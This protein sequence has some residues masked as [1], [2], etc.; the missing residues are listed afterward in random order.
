V[1]NST[2]PIQSLD[3]SFSCAQTQA[4]AACMGARNTFISTSSVNRW[5]QGLINI[6]K[7]SQITL[8]PHFSSCRKPQEELLTR[9]STIFSPNFTKLAWGE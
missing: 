4:L 9:I 3:R 8:E 6:K 2:L 1:N 7:R 5:I